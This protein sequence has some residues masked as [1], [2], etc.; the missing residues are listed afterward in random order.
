MSNKKVAIVN[1]YFF[2]ALEEKM[3]N[4]LVKAIAASALISISL[5]GFISGVEAYPLENKRAT[6]PEIRDKVVFACEDLGNGIYGTVKKVV[7][8]T[9]NG[10]SFPVYTIE[11]VSNEYGL[12][13]QPMIVWTTTLSSDHPD[14]AYIPESRCYSVSAR[15]TNLARAFNLTTPDQVAKLGEMSFVGTVNGEKVVFVSY[16]PIH[17]SRENVIFTLKP[18]NAMNAFNTLTQFRIGMSDT[19][20]TGIGGSDLLIEQLPPIVE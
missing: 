19:P 16:E 6:T 7:R 17:A 13:G 9:S 18:E 4:N 8:E 12:D 11:D 10:G 2:N 1:H 3:N 20:T 15:L 14:G 5:P